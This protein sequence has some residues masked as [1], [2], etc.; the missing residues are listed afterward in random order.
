MLAEKEKKS[1][2]YPTLK[3]EAL[4]EEKQMKIKKFTKEY[5]AKLL[6]KMKSRSSSSHNG[7]PSSRP[8]ETPESDKTPPDAD[9]DPDCMDVDLDMQDGIGDPDESPPGDAME[10][11]SPTDDTPSASTTLVGG[12]GGDE[13]DPKQ[14]QFGLVDPRPMVIDPRVRS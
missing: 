7:K 12:W 13:V 1:A 3:L 8:M 10:A 2:S 9:A 5:T 4:S 14:S 6:H 11:I